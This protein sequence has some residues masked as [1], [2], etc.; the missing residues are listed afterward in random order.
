MTL[1]LTLNVRS[2]V[3]VISLVT[4]P[5]GAYAHGGGLDALGCHEKRK[6]GDYH[7]HQGGGIW[8]FIDG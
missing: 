5:V 6:T 2:F 8:V 7:C 3:L 4:N 1:K